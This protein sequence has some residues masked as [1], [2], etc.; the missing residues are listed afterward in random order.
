M[1]GS[2][3]QDELSNSKTQSPCT[4]NINIW[5][6]LHS[7]FLDLTKHG[8]L[9]YCD[10]ELIQEESRYEQVLELLTLTAPKP[11]TDTHHL[12]E[13]CRNLLDAKNPTNK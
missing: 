7:Y 3:C 9:G 5:D 13:A 12:T 2:D 11:V 6:R 4:V 8:N 10:Y 1:Q